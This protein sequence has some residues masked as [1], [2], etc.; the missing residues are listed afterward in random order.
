MKS[1]LFFVLI[2]AC[3]F[4]LLFTSCDDSGSGC[5]IYLYNASDTAINKIIVQKAGSG[6]VLFRTTTGVDRFTAV[7]FDVDYSGT[8]NMW[9]DITAYPF[10]VFSQDFNIDKGGYVGVSF[11]GGGGS[12][13]FDI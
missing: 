5:T 1:K 12:Y 7:E 8:V 11:H 6:E 9:V 13:G 4:A 10:G 2:L 3:L